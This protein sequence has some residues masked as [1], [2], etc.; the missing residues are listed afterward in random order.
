MSCF[1]CQYLL[2]L[3]AKGENVNCVYSSAEFTI[4]FLL[5]LFFIDLHFDECAPTI[6]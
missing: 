3:A 4:D 2:W 6:K 1:D 5:L